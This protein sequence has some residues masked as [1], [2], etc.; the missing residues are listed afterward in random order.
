M[1]NLEQVLKYWEKDSIIDQTEPG[2]E[3]IRIPTLHSKYL[4]I[5]IK[6]KIAAKKAHFDYLRMRKIR[7]DYYGGRMSQEELDEYGWEPFQFVLKSDINAYLEADDNLI[8]LLEK[9]VYHEETVS[10]IESIMGELK[11][12]TFQLKDFI[13]WE[14]FIGGQ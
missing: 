1:E 8:K 2:K 7:L 4:G 13:G 11:S 12:R 6:H 9:K 5:L 3:L 10:V 14:K